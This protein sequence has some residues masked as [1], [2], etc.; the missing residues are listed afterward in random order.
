M[1]KEGLEPSPASVDRILNPA[2]L[3]FRH[4]GAARG[5][6]L[7][8]PKIFQCYASSRSRSLLSDFAC[9]FALASHF[10]GILEHQA[11][12]KPQPERETAS[13]SCRPLI[14]PTTHH[15]PLTKR[16]QLPLHAMSVIIPMGNNPGRQPF[17]FHRPALV[18][19]MRSLYGGQIGSV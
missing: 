14:K 2:R 19:T 7:I 10:A 1:P 18:L 4:F 15:S 12:V 5:I 3:P 6:I 13:E 8:I 16:K 11:I 9:G 17:L